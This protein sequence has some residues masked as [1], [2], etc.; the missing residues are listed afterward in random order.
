ME[1]DAQSSYYYLAG[2]GGFLVSIC[3]G[4]SSVAVV[5]NLVC[6]MKKEIAKQMPGFSPT[7]PPKKKKISEV[8]EF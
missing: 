6:F 2:P 7:P 8:V 4:P 5:K 1:L 3:N